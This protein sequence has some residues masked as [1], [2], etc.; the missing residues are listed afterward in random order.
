VCLVGVDPNQTSG[1]TAFWGM[2]RRDGC[3]V[4]CSGEVGVPAVEVGVE[5]VVEDSGADLK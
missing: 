5:L 2:C 1:G 4:R 3:G